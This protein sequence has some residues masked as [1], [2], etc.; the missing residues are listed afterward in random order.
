MF[1]PLYHIYG[2]NSHKVKEN[3][4]I[5]LVDNVIWIVAISTLNMPLS[6]EISWVEQCICIVFMYG[7]SLN[8]NLHTFESIV[9]DIND[10]LSW[11]I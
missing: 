11:S 8:L 2:S 5:S 3:K 9:E 10:F 1:W 4:T 7:M 6:I